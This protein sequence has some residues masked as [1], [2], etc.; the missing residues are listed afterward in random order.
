MKQ[1][2]VPNQKLESMVDPQYRGFYQD[3]RLEYLAV[4]YIS[5][6]VIQRI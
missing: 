2:L 1:L 5:Y 3:N 4:T 6:Q